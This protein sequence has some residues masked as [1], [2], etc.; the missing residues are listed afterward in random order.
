MKDE[1]R[2]SLGNEIE[3]KKVKIDKGMAKRVH[4]LFLFYQPL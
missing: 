3:Q 1:T 4:A 2:K